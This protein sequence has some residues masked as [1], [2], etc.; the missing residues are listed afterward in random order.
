MIEKKKK[1][2]KNS[3]VNRQVDTRVDLFFFFLVFDWRC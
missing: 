2:E 3:L 1:N